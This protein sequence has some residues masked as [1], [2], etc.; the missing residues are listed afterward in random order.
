ML[1]KIMI[2]VFLLL[3]ILLTG[4]SGN[5][6][7]QLKELFQTDYM[8][9]FGAGAV[10]TPVGDF[11]IRDGLLYFTDYAEK[12]CI[13]V[14]AKPD[15]RHLSVYE[16]EHSACNAIADGAKVFPYDGK[17][18]RIKDE[19]DG[20]KS[21]LVVSQMDGS[22][23]KEVGSFDSG[24]WLMDA[25]IVRNKMYYVYVETKDSEEAGQMPTM[26][27]IYTMNVLDLDTLEQR[28]VI[29]KIKTD[30]FSLR[31]GT[32]DFFIYAL[33][34]D[35]VSGNYLFD[36]ETETSQRLPIETS[37]R[38]K[39][40]VAADGKSFY[41]TGNDKNLYCY[42]IETQENEVV[43]EAAE[44]QTDVLAEAVCEDGLFFRVFPENELYIRTDDEVKNLELSKRL[45]TTS[46]WLSG[47]ENITETG[48]Y[49][50]YQSNYTKEGDLLNWYAYIETEDL[51][52]GTEDVQILYTPRVSS[53]WNIVDAAE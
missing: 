29:S 27:L 36:H 50:N 23:P 11:K 48:V 25:V 13:P 8:E 42:H 22:N 19:D 40:I 1:R 24:D 30:S 12:I 33:T 45:P 46:A 21:T 16:D 20:Q 47:V 4:C 9:L 5:D 51:L 52:N 2:S 28:A 38:R 18:Y 7:Q 37:D 44:G 39:I 3:Q 26:N 10:I 41:Y 15:C 17:L 14:C 49:F 43:Y 53:L 6:E 31:G 32:E 34:G 35:T